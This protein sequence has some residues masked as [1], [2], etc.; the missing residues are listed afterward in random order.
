M[1]DDLGSHSRTRNWK[2]EESDIE[3]IL[4]DSG[5]VLTIIKAAAMYCTSVRRL[6]F[7]RAS[8]K[9]QLWCYHGFSS[10]N[11]SSDSILE[12]SPDIEAK[13]E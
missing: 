10:Y 2:M 9:T 11:S 7:L 1:D 5:P 3:C 6:S 12:W 8:W 4:P 13:A